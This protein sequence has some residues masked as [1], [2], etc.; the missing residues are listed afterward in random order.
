MD[1]LDYINIAAIILAPI[2]A[3]IV[4][5]KLQDR[6]R[7]RQDKMKI[8]K[9]LMTNRLYGW[10][11][12]SVHALNIIEI[13]FADDEKV[14]TQ[15]KAYYDKLCVGNPTKEDFKKIETEQCKL[16]EEIAK[17]L[18]YENKIT[19]ETIQNPYIPKGMVNSMM[20]Q[21][22]FQNGQLEIMELMKSMLPIKNGGSSDGQ[23]T[24]GNS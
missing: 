3:V 19:W 12:A 17:S 4:G 5:Q 15:W 2:V 24:H 9:T 22:Q 14:R 16:L 21:Q 13:V 8:F 1:F 23:A 10:N 11:D 7:K 20:Q 18:G 6:A